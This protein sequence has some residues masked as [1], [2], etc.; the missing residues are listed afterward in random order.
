LLPGAYRNKAD[1][2]KKLLAIATTALTIAAFTTDSASARHHHRHHRMD[3]GM[4][5]GMGA[6]GMRGNNAELGGNNGNSA[7]GSNS[8]GHIPGGYN[9]SGK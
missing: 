6:G 2:M 3:H 7:S 8:L 4:T 9:G 5:T 1:E